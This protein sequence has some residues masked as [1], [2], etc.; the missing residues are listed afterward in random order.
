MTLTEAGHRVAER[1]AFPSV[2]GGRGS[3]F[4]GMTIHEHA[5]LELLCA[6]RASMD[7]AV[8]N[9]HDGYAHFAMLDADAY[10]NALGAREGER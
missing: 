6:A 8:A 5:T 7:E 1:P 9:D 10:C 2:G 3:N 4:L